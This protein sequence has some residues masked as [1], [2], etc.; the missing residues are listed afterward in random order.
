MIYD[1]Y[2]LSPDF[3]KHE[4]DHAFK[5]VRFKGIKSLFYSSEFALSSNSES[6]SE[7]IEGL[8]CDNDILVLFEEFY[9]Q[10]TIANKFTGSVNIHTV[11]NI[12]GMFLDSDILK[13]HLNSCDFVVLA[14][15]VVNWQENILD[16]SVYS[17]D[18]KTFISQNYSSIL[19]VDTGFYGDISENASAFSKFTGLTF[20][21]MKV[22][23]DHFLLALENIVLRWDAERKQSLLR[24]CN[25]KAASYAMSFDFVRKMADVL[26]KSD[27]V[28]SICK[29]YEIMFAPKTV[30]YHSFTDDVDICCES[31]L[32]NVDMISSFRSSDANYL[33]FDKG[34]SFVV[35]ISTADEVLGMVEVSNVAYPGNI[36]EYLSVALDIAKAS[37]LTL[38]N[39]RR[40]QAL[41]ESRK[42]YV[43][44]ADMLRTTNRILRHDIANSLQIVTSALD[45]YSNSD[46][47][48]FVNMAKKAAYKGVSIIGH[49]R[50]F[51]LATS[52]DAVLEPYRVKD[53]VINTLEKYDISAS[54]N[55]DCLVK[56]DAALNS[57]VDNIVSN[58]LVHGKSENM[59]INIEN[60][61]GICRIE[62]MDDGIGIPD[63]IKSRVFDEGFKYGETGH[64]GF[65]LFIVKKTV[66]RYGGKVEVENNIPKGTRFI[67]EMNAI[68]LDDL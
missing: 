9:P 29:L 30:L 1:M 49:M 16:F 39:I 3:I 40:Y 21:V 34:S 8:N 64:T 55:G 25:K 7:I 24:E 26:N 42:K 62:F 35:K 37:S 19:V 2:F 65:G 48:Q 18:P 41:S 32:M 33:T 68:S 4:I 27:A 63:D 58:A 23:M 12:C 57:V 52:S 47:V 60:D 51:D 38:L 6:V 31:S 66:E 67:I 53:F 13:A 5:D 17:I 54:V 15:W 22:T 56:A 61:N 11:E 50:D 14:S 59:H 46:D 10:P 36:E 28:D 45:M 20:E 43:E 44:I